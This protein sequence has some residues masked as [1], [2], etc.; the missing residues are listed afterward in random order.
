MRFTSVTH[1][2]GREI[3]KDSFKRICR[4]GIYCFAMSDGGGPG[5]ETGAD[6]VTSAITEEFEKA[7]E[8]TVERASHCIWSAVEAFK[9]QIADD[10][11]YSEMTATAAVLITDGEKAV[12]SHIGDTRIYRFTKGLVEFITNDHTE[13]MEK[14]SAG[15]IQFSELRSLMPSPLTRIISDESESEPETEKAFSVNSKT[16]FLI[17]TDG[18][19]VNMTESEMEDA[20]K[21]ARSS[22]EWLGNM[23]HNLESTAPADCGNITAAAIIM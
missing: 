16:A 8:V 9:K 12:C 10:P 11:V 17:C 20:L 18:F 19:W 6:I 13:A 5:G 15:E 23:L 4:S 1:R 14:Y 22:K 3:N 7:P 21:K 2:G